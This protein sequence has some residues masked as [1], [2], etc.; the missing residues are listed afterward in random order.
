M[1]RKALIAE[2]EWGIQRRRDKARGLRI[3]IKP[4]SAGVKGQMWKWA[5]SFCLARLFSMSRSLYPS[6]IMTPLSRLVS[7]PAAT[8]DASSLRRG[9]CCSIRKCRHT[10]VS[11]M[12]SPFSLTDSYNRISTL[13]RSLSTLADSTVLKKSLGNWD[14]IFRSNLKPARWNFDKGEGPA[15]ARKCSFHFF[16]VVTETNDRLVCWRARKCVLR[17]L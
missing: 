16:C 10:F 2:R 6:S 1:S 11:V 7:D 17:V 5:H 14:A 12:E 8:A 15:A 4:L 13:V 3:Y 9:G